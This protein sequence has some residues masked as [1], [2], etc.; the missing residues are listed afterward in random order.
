MIPSGHIHPSRLLAF[1]D[2]SRLFSCPVACFREPEQVDCKKIA[3][4]N[5][6]EKEKINRT[7]IEGVFPNTYFFTKENLLTHTRYF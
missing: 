1:F 3:R 6:F 4:H 5:K 7:T 2:S